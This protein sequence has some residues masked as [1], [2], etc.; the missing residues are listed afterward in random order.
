MQAAAR[1]R[2]DSMSETRPRGFSEYPIPPDTC[3]RWRAST[4]CYDLRWAEPSTSRRAIS[5]DQA[6]GSRLPTVRAL[7]HR[8]HGWPATCVQLS[9]SSRSSPR[10]GI[11]TATTGIQSSLRRQRSSSKPGARGTS[12]DL[13]RLTGP[14]PPRRNFAEAQKGEVTR[15]RLPD[16][17]GGAKLVPS[18]ATPRPWRSQQR[19]DRAGLVAPFVPFR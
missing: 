12:P 15:L 9:T 14:Q 1:G 11:R 5:W 6:R 7:R 10:R 4:L 16:C 19:R 18:R 3:Q 8:S 13:P 2:G 17:S